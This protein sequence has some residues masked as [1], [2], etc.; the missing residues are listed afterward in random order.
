MMT[1]HLYETHIKTKDLK[2]SIEFYERLGMKLAH[3][4]KTRKAAFLWFGN[5]EEKKQ[6]LGIWEVPLEKYVD[7]HFAFGVSLEEITNAISWLKERNIEPRPDFGLEPIEP[8]IHTWMPA[9][10]VYFYDPDG[11]SLEFIHV[12]SDEP[13]KELNVMYLSEWQKLLEEK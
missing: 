12:L 6:M 11:N 1:N 13:N 3:I 5:S 9:A 2:R 7:S 8:I 10:S 4:G